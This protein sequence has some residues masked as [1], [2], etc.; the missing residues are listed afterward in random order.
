MRGEPCGC[1]GAQQGPTPAFLEFEAVRPSWHH[2]IL[3]ASTG[4]ETAALQS[5]LL[6]A[7]SPPADI[8]R[9]YVLRAKSTYILY[10]CL[11]SWAG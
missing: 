10:I 9:I 8:L 4:G 7:S 3:S 2:T 6:L 11:Y 1:G 5:E